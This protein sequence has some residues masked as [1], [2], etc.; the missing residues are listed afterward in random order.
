M[1][2]YRHTTGDAVI[3]FDANLKDP[4][5]MILEFIKKW[6]EGY[7]VVYGIRNQTKDSF[8]LGYCRKL[9]YKIINKFSE[10]KLPVNA[11]S[12]RLVDRK[13]VDELIKIDDYKPYVRGLISS[14]GFKQIGIE[15]I[16]KSR[17]SGYSKSRLHYLIDFSIN[18]LIN[19][20]HWPIRICTYLGAFML[21]LSLAGA[22]I[23]LII[24]LVFW[25]F[26]LPVLAAVA[27]LILFFCGVQLFFLGIIGEYVG[28]IHFQ[29]RKKPFVIIKEKINF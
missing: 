8:L 18:A 23:A 26:S 16:R 1:V 12:F 13:L 15:Y 10:E 24:K 2:G 6:E 29:V 17:P 3:P 9:F 25:S 7:D 11:G 20:S 19:H 27:L 21:A 5:E 14:F 4:P 28:A 22:L